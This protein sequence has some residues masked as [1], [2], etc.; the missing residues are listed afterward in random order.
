MTDTLLTPNFLETFLTRAI[1]ESPRVFLEDLER[2][3][4]ND[5]KLEEAN[6]R[7]REENA[8]LRARLKRWE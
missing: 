2:M 1:T 8:E 7:L 3:F 4:E 5:K 6:M